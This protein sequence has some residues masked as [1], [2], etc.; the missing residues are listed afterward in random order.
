MD[1]RTFISGITLAL[2]AA[3]LAAEA[4]TALGDTAPNNQGPLLLGVRIRR[5]GAVPSLRRAAHARVPASAPVEVGFTGDG[6][7]PAAVR[8]VPP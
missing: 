6:P 7:P 4:Q 8:G 3:P 1:R 5:R 2:L